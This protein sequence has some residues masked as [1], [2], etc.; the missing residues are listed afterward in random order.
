[1]NRRGFLG[2]TAAAIG[3]MV[4]DPELALW[5]PGRKSYVFL[6]APKIRHVS[7]AELLAVTFDRVMQ[8]RMREGQSVFWNDE[9]IIRELAAAEHLRLSREVAS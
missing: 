7:I 1:M 5:V 4:L 9:R 8:E 6:A 2:L 3:G